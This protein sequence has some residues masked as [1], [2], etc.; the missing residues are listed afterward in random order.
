MTRW[1]AAFAA[2]VILAPASLAADGFKVQKLEDG[3][4]ADELS[5]EVVA[6]LSPTGN[7]VLDAAGKTVCEIWLAKQ[8]AVKPGFEPTLTILYPLESGSL[9]G[10]LHFPR[11]GSDF[12]GQDIGQGVY[13]LRYGNQPVDGNHV[14]T[15]ETRDFLLMLP[16]A[17]DRD[18][19]TLAGTE[20]FATSAEAAGSTHPAIMPMLKP[21]EGD[22]PAVRRVED[23][24]WWVLRLAGSD[25]KGGKQVLEMVVSGKSA[26]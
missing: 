23:M 5:P 24:E 7:K 4:P 6:K 20:F 11:K 14:G 13:T 3:P 19:K 17:S 25:A 10:A 1:L 2:L 15:F 12:R 22:A 21:E 9:V 16:A 26:E 18:P 8:L